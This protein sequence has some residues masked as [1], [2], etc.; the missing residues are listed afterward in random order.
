MKELYSTDAYIK[1]LDTTV[2]KVLD[3]NDIILDETI[4]YPRGGGQPCDKGI[5]MYNNEKITVNKVY[6]KDNFVIHTLDKPIEKGANVHLNINWDYRYNLMK[7]HTSLHILSSVVW[8]IYNAKVTGGNIEY[9]KA[10]LDFDMQEF[11]K[12]IAEEIV[13]KTNERIHGNHDVTIN[14]ISREE[15]EKNPNLIRTKVSLLPTSIKTIRVVKIGD[16]DIQADGGLHVHNT[17]EIKGISLKSIS[18]KGKGRKRITI[19]LIK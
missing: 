2:A 1:E 4:F 18:N 19:Q 6:K 12:T 15:L 13:K 10:R 3:N 14:F 8:D 7:L 9:S 11:N 17:S 16:I 5:I